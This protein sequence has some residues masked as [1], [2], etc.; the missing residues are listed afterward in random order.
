MIGEV[1]KISLDPVN[2]KAVVKMHIDSRFKEIPDD[3][4]AGILT[5]PLRSTKAVR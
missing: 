2:F 4:S 1:S 5:S 3:S